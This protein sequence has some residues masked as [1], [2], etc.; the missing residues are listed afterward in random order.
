MNRSVGSS[1]GHVLWW[2][3][4]A[5]PCTMILGS[6]AAT[7]G[8]LWLDSAGASRWMIGFGWPFDLSAKTAQELAS[9]LLTLHAAFSTLYFS[10]TLL[11]L[12]LAASN[13]GVRLIDRWIS[14]TKIRVTLGLLLSLVSASLILLLCVDDRP[15]AAVPR[16]SL[17]TVVAATLLT[18]GWMTHA[19]HHLGRTVHVDTSIAQLG[20]DAAAGVGATESVAPPAIDRSTAIP[21]RAYRTGYI[22]EVDHERILAEARERG[23]FVG[24]SQTLGSYT[25]AGEQIG[26]AIGA[27]SAEWVTDAITCSPFRK[28]T[29]GPVFES[30]L[31]VEVAARALSPAVNDLY[32]ALACCDRIASMLAA[33]LNEPQAPRWLADQ[34]GTAR[35]ELRGERVT[36]FMDMPL[37]A[38]RQAAASYPTVITHMLALIARLPGSQHPDGAVRS[39]LLAHVDAMAEHATV[40]AE[41]EDDRASIAAA[42]ADARRRL[43]RDR[44]PD[45]AFSVPPLRGPQSSACATHA[46]AT[47]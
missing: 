47:G 5:L 38:L 28:D 2:N 44:S 39:F 34:D 43:S 45:S 16:L 6:V 9:G 19:L 30:N 33:A 36:D 11:V 14:D 24:L 35:L 12:T 20:R 8:L 4:W 40:R 25:I 22:E 32:T 46:R 7:A 3:F 31:L 17:V 10:I 13:L 26:W 18:L 23:A 15:G 1:G 41:I 37:K 29:S 27:A 42:Q 21:V